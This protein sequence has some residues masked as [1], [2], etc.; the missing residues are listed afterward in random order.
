VRY[1]LRGNACI[2][3]GAAR[4]IGRATAELLLDEGADVVL[5]A[6]DA[7]AVAQAAGERGVPVVADVREPDA[8]EHVV[9]GCL[10]RFGR[11]DVLV[12]SAG[13]L[14]PTPLAELTDADW[15]AEWDANVIAP[16][17]FMRAAAPVMADAGYGRI[18]NVASDAGKR[19]TPLNVAYS[20]TSA[21]QL[22]LSRVFADLYAGKGV[23]VNAVAP[24]AVGHESAA[25]AAGAAG[26]LPTIGRPGRPDET[27]AV[28]VFLCSKACSAVAGAAWSADGG[29]IK[30][31]V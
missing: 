11:L 6:D 27:A 30:A 3:T 22:S 23:L 24:N 25:D 1:G 15:Q 17:R 29:A 16:L 26:Q 18:V 2:V 19:P 20:V 8:A 13:G 12:N 7:D 4:G 5:V 10:E 21:A 9:A 28:V 14:T 31:I